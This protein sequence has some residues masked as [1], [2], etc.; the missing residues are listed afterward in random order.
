MTLEHIP[1]TGNFIG[2]VRK[3]IGSDET[4]FFFQIPEATRI[5]K[6]CAFVDIYY[7][8]CSYFSPGSLARLFRRNGFEVLKVDIEYDNQYLTIEA[9]P[10]VN[11]ASQMKLANE[12]DLETLT[13]LVN[14]FPARVGNKLA[15]WREL[16]EEATAAGQKVALWGSG[17][18]GVSFLTSL[19]CPEAVSC[20]V[21]INPHRWGH[22]MSGTGHPIVSPDQLR[23][24]KPDLIIVM[25]RIYRDEIIRDLH[26]RELDARVVAL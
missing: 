6:D 7:E 9:R 22:Y 21:D 8:H 11:G 23:E 16:L 26:E 13:S 15:E 12:N 20:V 4:Y 19:D 3:A 24:L 25:N 18:K 5:L 2:M 14:D 17:S 10:A 1:D